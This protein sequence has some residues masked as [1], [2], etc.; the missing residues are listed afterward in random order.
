VLAADRG[1]L[2][3]LL[4]QAGCTVTSESTSGV[5]P[6][7]D[8]GLPAADLNRLPARNG[9]VLRQLAERTRSLERAFFALTGSESADVP[10]G[11]EMGAI[12]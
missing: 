4:R 11:Q 1:Q 3:A 2:A 5:M 6:V 8:C 7:A 9:I 10:A 12:R